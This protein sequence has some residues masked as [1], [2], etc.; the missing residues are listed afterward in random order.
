M[1]CGELLREISFDLYERYV[2]LEHIGKLFR[3]GDSK[4]R[5]LD[6]GGHT[7]ALWP[8][9]TSLAAALIPD[10][11]VVVVDTLGTPGLQNYVQA[12][13]WHL[14]FRDG[15]FDLVCSLDI[16]EHV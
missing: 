15:T 9:F 4:Y 8:G 3:E 2:L 10:A 5:V 13:G 6:I 16:L 11:T 7:P 1:T 14:P 12:N